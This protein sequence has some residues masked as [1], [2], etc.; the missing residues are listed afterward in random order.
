MMDEVESTL[1]M[2]RDWEFH[3]TNFIM[4]EKKNPKHHQTNL[5]FCKEY[6]VPLDLCLDM[7]YHDK[8][9]WELSDDTEV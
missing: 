3:Y 4:L 2:H 9:N 1:K 5:T 8:E 7:L 6:N